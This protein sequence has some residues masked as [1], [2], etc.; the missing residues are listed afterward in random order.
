M[1][2]GSQRNHFEAQRLGRTAEEG[3]SGPSS[4]GRESTTK[5]AEDANGK[6]SV[7]CRICAGGG[8]TCRQRI[9]KLGRL[10]PFEIENK[11]EI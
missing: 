10:K 1:T 7:P 9:W 8:L 2:A 11:P 3:L 4:R 5:V 6:V